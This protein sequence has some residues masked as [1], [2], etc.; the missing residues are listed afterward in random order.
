[1]WIITNRPPA[2]P[3]VKC[4]HHRPMRENTSGRQMGSIGAHQI[5]I[6]PHRCWADH[7]MTF[8]GKILMGIIEDI[9]HFGVIMRIVI[10]AGVV[11]LQTELIVLRGNGNLLS[12][13]LL[14][15]NHGLMTT[16]ACPPNLSRYSSRQ[17]PNAHQISIPSLTSKHAK[18]M[19]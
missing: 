15:V 17:N 3:F 9:C 18:L 5:I 10:V 19:L 16:L 14:P 4:C 12:N 6:A 2:T 11:N 7:L 8:R 1:M 13:I